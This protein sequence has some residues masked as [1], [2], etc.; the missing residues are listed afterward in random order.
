MMDRLT[1][2]KVLEILQSRASTYGSLSHVYRQEATASFLAG[3]VEQLTSTAEGEAESEGYGAL[4]AYV[5]ET[6]DGDAIE[7]EFMGYL[8]QRVVGAVK[9]ADKAAV[10]KALQKQEDFLQKHLLVW[11]PESCRDVQKAAKTGFYQGIAQI[12]AEHLAVE[13]DTLDEFLATVA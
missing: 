8:C 13:R 7:L 11:V 1:E 5:A 12:T 3:L 4:R 2:A 9:A 6:K 10:A